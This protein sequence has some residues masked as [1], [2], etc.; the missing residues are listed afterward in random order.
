VICKKT[1]RKE[2]NEKKRI[3]N[4]NE[5]RKLGGHRTRQDIVCALYNE[6]EIRMLDRNTERGGNLE[7]MR[8]DCC[9]K[10]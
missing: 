7:G 5:E 3:G 6:K 2:E 4:W 8:H 10:Q 9:R 1:K